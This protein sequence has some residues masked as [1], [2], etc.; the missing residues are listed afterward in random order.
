M[1]ENWFDKGLKYWEK[2]DYEQAYECFC[3]GDKE[4]NADCTEQLGLCYQ[5]GHG[6][7]TD[8]QKAAFYNEKAAKAG[9]PM[10]MYDTGLNYERGQGVQQDI[11]RALFWLEK[12]AEKEYADAYLE[13]GNLYYYGEYVQK[14]HEKSF[15]YYQHGAELGENRSKT[16]L[17]EFYIEG[18]IV[19][20]DLEKAKM[21]YREAFDSYYEMANVDNDCVAQFWLGTIYSDGLPILD[22]AFDYNQA[23]EWYLKA[24]LQNHDDAQNNLGIMYTHG[25]GVVQDYK[26][27]F[28]WFV[29][30]SK[31]K[32]VVAM[33][34]VANCYYSGKGVEQDYGKAAEYHSK[35]A[36]LGYANSQ[37][38][39][40]E[41]YLDGKGIEQND[42]KGAYWLKVA[43]ENGERSAFAPMG[44]CYRKGRGVEKDEKKAFELYQQGASMGN[45][46]SKVSVAECLIEGWGTKFE[47]KQAFKILAS[48]CNEEENYRENLVTVTS[49]DDEKGVTFYENPLDEI[50]I[51]HYAK[52]YYL[53]GTL[54][55]TRKGTD[56]ANPSKALALLRM[57]ER[58]GYEDKGHPE[59]TAEKLIDKIESENQ[60]LEGTSNIYIEIRDLK[61][62]GR[63]GRFDIYVHHADGTE[64][65]VRFG[66]DRRKFCYLLL[67]LLVSNKESVQGLMARYFCYGRDRLVSLARITELAD[68]EGPEKWIEKFIYADEYDKDSKEWRYKYTNWMYS[69]EQRKASEFFKEVCSADELELYQIRSTGGRDS[70]ASIAIRPEQIIIPDSLI[71]YTKNLPS[72]KL[73]LSYKSVGNRPQNIAIT[74]KLNPNKYED[75]N[76]DI[77]SN[78]QLIE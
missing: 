3:E 34:N 12:A 61:K 23:A 70:I 8:L 25:M 28:E 35:A 22:I 60:D 74:K 32:N 36:H 56:G 20:K 15:K 6:V 21:L 10:A 55:Y 2:K 17:A 63:M 44:D 19:E 46:R 37:E 45:L 77:E 30:A 66:T 62:R 57:A 51:K 43:C 67:L 68:E 71:K 78:D 18:K 73:M 31:R 9:V 69:N 52:A 40:G 38:V 7:D 33:S 4:G 64:S 65:N 59:L 54:T 47:D 75:W 1:E 14:D 27:A 48:I 13:L 24:A 11:K 41:M 26:Q 16:G 29:K 72:R 49:H 53:L 39:L 42:A 58:L 50:S 5:W 76:E